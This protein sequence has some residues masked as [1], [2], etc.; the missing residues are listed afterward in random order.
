LFIAGGT[1]IAP[2]RSMIREAVAAGHQAT[3]ALVYSAR[4]PAEFA[5]LSEWRELAEEGRLR[6]TLTLTGASTD[7]EHARGRTGPMHLMDLIRPDSVC[8]VCGPHLMVTD[9]TSALAALGVPQERIRTED[10]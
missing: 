1:G 4:T 2:L 5:Y 7:W 8:F 3:M 6:L 10:W 9:V